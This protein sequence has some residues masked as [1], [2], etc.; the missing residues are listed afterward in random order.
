MGERVGNAFRGLVLAG[1]LVTV[2]AV[3]AAFWM[4]ARG[5]VLGGIIVATVTFFAFKWFWRV[6]LRKRELLRRQYYVGRRVGTHW[7]YDELHGGEIQSL[8][9]PL[10]YAGRGEYDIHVPGEGD[11]K[12]TM[13]NWA[14]DRRAEVIERLLTAF[15]RSQLHFDPDAR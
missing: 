7:V 12:K 10:E 11:W 8:E 4:L 5:S 3:F 2:L 1:I 13:P 9:F 14:R 6:T 15:K